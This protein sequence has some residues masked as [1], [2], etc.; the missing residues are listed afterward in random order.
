MFFFKP[1]M[2]HNKMDCGQI[3]DTIHIFF[4]NSCAI[5]IFLI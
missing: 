4:D 3:G 1:N 5:H 2:S